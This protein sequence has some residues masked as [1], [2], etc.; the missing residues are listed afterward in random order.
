MSGTAALVLALA[1]ALLAAGAS[2][3]PGG[4]G[5]LRGLLQT[6][7]TAREPSGGRGPAPRAA[8]A[9]AERRAHLSEDERGVMTRQIVQA[10]SEIMNSDC[11]LSRDYQGWVDFGRRDAQ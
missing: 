9:R 5:A 2:P 4:P 11:A 8:P 7:Q 1:A 10:I 6:Q 3:A